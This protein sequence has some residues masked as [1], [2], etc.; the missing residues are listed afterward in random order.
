MQREERQYREVMLRLYRSRARR[1]RRRATLNR[2]G[3]EAI[4]IKGPRR[5]HKSDRKERGCRGYTD[6]GPAE[7]GEERQQRE[8]MQMMYRSWARRGRRRATGKRRDAEAIQIKGPQME[9]ESDTK[10][11]GCRGYTDQ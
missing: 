10:E 1:G 7:G 11:R 5:K 4:Q 2:A 9:E 3:A 8:R 6:Q